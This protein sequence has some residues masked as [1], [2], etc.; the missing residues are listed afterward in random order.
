[1]TSRYVPY[2]TTPPGSSRSWSATS[3]SASWIAIWVIVGLAVHSAVAAIAN[4]G[5][6]V[7]TGRNGIAG[8]LDHAGDNA[9]NVPLIGDALRSPLSGAAGS[10]ATSRARA[11]S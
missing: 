4:F 8:N 2:A 10:P 6:D 7:E 11:H 3:S 5:A 1:M 9:D